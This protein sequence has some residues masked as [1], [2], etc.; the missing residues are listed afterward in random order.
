MGGLIHVPDMADFAIDELR[1]WH[2]WEFTPPIMELSGKKT[3]ELTVIRRA[4]LRFML[5]SPEATA[6][7]FVEEQ[8]Q[9][10]AEWVKDTEELLKLESDTK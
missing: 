2:R 1:R 3:H 9:R 10:D 6:R 5:Q 8:R 4:I 7:K